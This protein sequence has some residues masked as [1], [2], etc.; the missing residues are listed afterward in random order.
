MFKNHIKIA[1]RSLKKQTFLTLL[2]TMGLAIG[3]AGA[4]L[5][6]LF[7][8]D[9]LSFDKMFTDAERIH[10]INVD[11]K[12]GG[13]ES[14][15]AET[16]APMGEAMV[17][18]FPQVTMTTRFNTLGTTLIRRSDKTQNTKEE[19]S[20]FVDDTF[21][22]MFGMDLIKGDTKTALSEPN[23]LIL[24][25]SA[26][27]KHFGT[28]S[29]VGETMVLNNSTTYTVSGVVQ[30]MPKNSFLRDYSLFLAMA[31]NENAT[32]GEWTSHNFP[33]FIKLAPKANI[34]DLQE[35]LRN[36]MGKYVIPY[37]QRYFPGITEEA[38]KASGNHLIYSTIP[39]V[40]IHLNSQ[41]ES[42]ISPNSSM[43]N[44]YI[45]SF[46]GLFL[47]VLA[48]VNFMNLST[49]YSL[50]RSKE[51][52]IR[53]TLGSSKAGLL[54]QFFMESGLIT[55][56]SLLF[57][58]VLATFLLP[59]FNELAGKEISIPFANPYFW[60]IVLVSASILGILSGWYPAFFMSRFMPVDV[61]K[62]SGDKSIGGGRVRNSLVI[63]QFAISVFLIISTLI[64]YQQLKYIQSK[65]LG[66]SKDQVLII[67]DVFATGDQATTFKEQVSQL[68]QVKSATLSSF[69]PT[70]SSRTNTSLFR[71]GFSDPESA[72]NMQLWRTDHD[73][74]ST[75]DIEMVSGRNF[76]PQFPADSSAIILNE[77]AAAIL[78]MDS[79]EVLG[80]RLSG[81]LGEENPSF[82]NVIGVVKDFHYETLRK[83]IGALSITLSNSTGN[84]AVKL[85]AGDFSEATAAIQ[86]IWNNLAPG[87]PFSYR[88]MDDAFNTTYEAD[89][90]LGRIFITFTILSIFIA[91]LGL[92]GLATFNA[93]KRTKEIG[94][95]KILGAS[96][97]QITFRL[98]TDFL[99]LVAVSILISVPIGWL[100]MNKWLQDFSYR[101]DI[102]LTVF[103]LAAALAVFIAI[104]TVSYQS[105]KAAITN[106]VKS[107][108][109]E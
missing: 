22:D 109:T 70:P 91:C 47:I 21:F 65:D 71:E 33:T 73:Y 100:A 36:M 96:V 55:L 102:S 29:A 1:W 74:I 32:D 19:Y 58:L 92:F 85:A 15:F 101:I 46:I 34:E 37:A 54:R 41:L 57:A 49:A 35:P 20:T 53:K 77:S 60:G 83:D 81:D 7:I 4:L 106:P 52:G 104:I 82:L 64:V 18:D 76:N 42:E 67:E 3:M 14:V 27:Q 11:V 80:T 63:F 75:L 51:V 38:F 45:L 26:A 50:K 84:M 12:F 66:F 48:S 103:V 105:I 39:L 23:T 44:I 78:G 6:A 24:T 107:L 43:Q 87:Q 95:R 5:I 56:I 8:H 31:G 89:R 2:N 40:D 98:T 90:N 25:E 13:T 93:E 10:R 59:F 99:R 30:D 108:R 16:S 68:A 94:V 28:L 69:L 88:F 61:L 86:E 62:G 9:E 79:K 97:S 72:I 17:A